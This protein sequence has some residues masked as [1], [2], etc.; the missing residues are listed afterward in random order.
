VCDSVALQT[1][2]REVAD[3]EG[4]V[5]G[6]I[7]AAGVL[8]EVKALDYTP[9]QFSRILDINVTG[10]FLSAQACAR[11]MIR[12]GIKGGSICIVASMSGV[13]ANRVHLSLVP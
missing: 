3:V 5:D 10:A 6:L 11:E 9:Q 8:E 4:R 7:A 12:L 1:L 13:I 2:L